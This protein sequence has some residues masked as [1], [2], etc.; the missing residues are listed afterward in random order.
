MNYLSVYFKNEYAF[1]IIS[2]LLMLLVVIVNLKIFVRRNRLD[3]IKLRFKEVNQREILK[4]MGIAFFINV[5]VTVFLLLIKKYYVYN[6]IWSKLYIEDVVGILLTGIIVSLSSV[7]IEELMLRGFLFNKIHLR[8]E[9]VVIIIAW[10]YAMFNVVEKGF[11][12]LQFLNVFL[13]AILLNLIYV[14]YKNLIYTI[15][16]NFIWYYTSNFI[17]S[18]N[19]E[20]SNI[21]VPSVIN[22]IYGNYD[23]FSGGEYGIFGSVIF[24]LVLIIV[25]AVLIRKMGILNK[26]KL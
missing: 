26:E 14:K 2:Y 21:E 24:L 16:F 17:F 3:F 20:P 4:L 25:D 18:L 5:G 7:A 11:N 13:F 22:L 6:Y 15:A 9:T 10:V 8:D 23:I 12:L 1:N 19:L